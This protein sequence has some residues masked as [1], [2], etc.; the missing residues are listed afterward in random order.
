MRVVRTPVKKRPSD[1]GS[2]RKRA[3][4]QAA[5][6]SMAGLAGDGVRFRRAINRGRDYICR[7]E[8]DN[9]SERM[10]RVVDEP[11]GSG[12]FFG[13]KVVAAAF[14]VAVFAWGIAFYGPPV[15]LNTLHASHGW[16]VS[17]ISAAITTQY[18]LSAVL[19][20]YLSDVHRRLGV[21]ATTRL[22]A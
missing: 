10:T 21:T 8:N 20:A 19:I 11:T 14:V 1:A 2:R 3:R 9:T 13:W 6:S 5:K 15:F 16:S 7:G 17:V 22:G 18:L 4:S 12:V